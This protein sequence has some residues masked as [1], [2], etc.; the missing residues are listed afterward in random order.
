M[1]E[2]RG[3]CGD[4][5][6]AMHDSQRATPPEETADGMRAMPSTNAARG[7]RRSGQV[8]EVAEALM[9]SPTDENPPAARYGR[10]TMSGMS[11]GATAATADGPMVPL[12]GEPTPMEAEMRV[13]HPAELMA[14]Q[15]P[16]RWILEAAA[17]TSRDQA[18]GATGSVARYELQSSREEGS[19]DEPPLGGLWKGCSNAEF[20]RNNFILIFM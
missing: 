1:L 9:P 7:R 13:P 10:L 2:D 6:D 16:S 18:Q 19:R 17:A 5:E 12:P 3:L 8:A 15:N 11:A 14:L 20:G 4:R